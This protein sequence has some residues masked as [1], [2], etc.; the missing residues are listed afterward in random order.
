VDET[1]KVLP[2]GSERTRARWR[3]YREWSGA[4]RHLAWV[5]LT[6]EPERVVVIIEEGSLSSSG[7]PSD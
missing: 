6:I 7:P 5:G 3:R 2:V 1:L 4:L